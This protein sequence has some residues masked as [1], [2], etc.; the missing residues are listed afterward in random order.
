MLISTASYYVLCFCFTCLRV[1][2]CIP[3]FYQLCSLWQAFRLFCCSINLTW[4][5]TTDQT[6]IDDDDAE[7]RRP[8]ATTVHSELSCVRMWSRSVSIIQIKCTLERD[9]HAT[10]LDIHADFD[11]HSSDIFVYK[12]SKLS[13]R[14]MLIIYQH[15]SMEGHFECHF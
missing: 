7:R 10:R 13:L 8:Q 5:S 6:I 1:F 3:L 12:F 9:L 11:L 4:L 2:M 15:C 14:P